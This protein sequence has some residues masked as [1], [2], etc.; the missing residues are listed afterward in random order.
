M[1]RA[2]LLFLELR[3][4]P[5]SWLEPHYYLICRGSSHSSLIIIQWVRLETLTWLDLHNTNTKMPEG[6]AKSDV[7]HVQSRPDTS[8]YAFMQ[9]INVYKKYIQLSVDIKIYRP[10]RGIYARFILSHKCIYYM[11]THLCIYASFG[12]YVILIQKILNFI[13]IRKS[14][15][16]RLIKR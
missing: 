1:A 6:Y 8:L 5:L 2:L 3:L 4:E 14:K 9:C 13:I 15:K 12:D 11:Y 7:R 16:E 10:G